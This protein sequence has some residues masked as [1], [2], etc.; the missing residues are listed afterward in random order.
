MKSRCFV[1]LKGD[2]FDFDIFRGTL[3]RLSFKGDQGAALVEPL[4]LG[5]P[6]RL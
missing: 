2:S 1:S 4:A 5:I 3:C 6:R